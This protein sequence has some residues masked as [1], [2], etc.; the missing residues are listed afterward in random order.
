MFSS[1]S[2]RLR[3]ALDAL[4]RAVPDTGWDGVFADDAERV[5][6]PTGSV[7]AAARLKPLAAYLEPLGEKPVRLWPLAVRH[8]TLIVAVEVRTDRPE[9][10]EVCLDAFVART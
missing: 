6:R 7:V 3:S 5:L 1:T 2:A 4:H 10:L 8:G 9:T